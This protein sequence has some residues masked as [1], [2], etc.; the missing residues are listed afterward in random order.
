MPQSVVPG[1]SDFEA[2]SIAKDTMAKNQV[3][4]KLKEHGLLSDEK[5]LPFKC[6]VVNNYEKDRFGHQ[7]QEGRQLRSSQRQQNEIEE[8]FNRMHISSFRDELRRYINDLVLVGR[9]IQVYEDLLSTFPNDQERPASDCPNSRENPQTPFSVSKAAS[10]SVKSNAELIDT[11]ASAT[12][13]TFGTAVSIRAMIVWCDSVGDDE[14]GTSGVM[15]LGTGFV[16]SGR[17]GRNHMLDDV[18]NNF[19]RDRLMDYINTQLAEDER[20]NARKAV[21]SDLSPAEIEQYSTLI[22]QINEA[23][24][25]KSDEELIAQIVGDRPVGNKHERN[26]IIRQAIYL[27]E[28][29][30]NVFLT[31]KPGF[32]VRQYSRLGPILHSV[33][34]PKLK[35]L[36]PAER[37]LNPGTDIDRDCNQ[38]RA[39]IAIFTSKTEWTVDQF[40]LALG[41]VERK[42]LTSFLEKRGPKNGNDKVFQ[43]AWEFFKRRELLGLSLTDASGNDGSLQERDANSRERSSTGGNE[44]TT[45]E[46]RTRRS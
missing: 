28:V 37:N 26:S 30:K 43:L 32:A 34:K 27:N 9:Y 15:S 46:K 10:Q 8:K 29:N 45:K 33:V 6:V 31:P 21:F 40:R 3:I 25:P 23:E 12:N 16:S 2:R 11:L 42:Q 39:M 41:S 36:T 22:M 14:R 13:M 5:I 35:A 24:Q 18:P 38:I 19:V 1:I 17:L 7:Q 44:G 20:E 4:I